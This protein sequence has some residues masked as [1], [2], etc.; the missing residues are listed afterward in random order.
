MQHKMLE[1]EIGL[2]IGPK[3]G[4]GIE[5]KG[6]QFPLFFDIHE[7]KGLLFPL[8]IVVLHVLRYFTESTQSLRR[9]LKKQLLCVFTTVTDQTFDTAKKKKP[10]KCSRS[11]T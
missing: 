6:F 11:T 9:C 5:N 7:Q 3:I 10:S 1:L 2:K 8:L 4:L